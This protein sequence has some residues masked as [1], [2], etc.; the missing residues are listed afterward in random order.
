MRTKTILYTT[1]GT[2]TLTGL[3]ATTLIVLTPQPLTQTKQTPPEPQYLTTTAQGTTQQPLTQRDTYTINDP[4]K[5]TLYDAAECGPTPE[6]ELWWTIG[7]IHCQLLDDG[8]TVKIIPGNPLDLT[9]Y[10]GT[11]IQKQMAYAFEY[12]N[13]SGPN[14]GEFK[15]LDNV[16]CANFTSQTLLARGWQMDNQWFNNGGNDVSYDWIYATGLREYTLTKPGVTELNDTQRNQVK[17]GDLAQFDWE[18]TGTT[19]RDH[20]AVVS[21]IETLPDGSIKIYVIEHTDPYN[22]RD[23]DQMINQTHPGATV[24]YISIPENM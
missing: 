9:K 22:Y 11:N 4:Q 14:T 13:T 16:D 8:T 10:T 6:G 1:I 19:D 15:Y 24:Y 2:L 17:I 12:W 18:S 3:I 23:V 20:T 5:D 21:K 7:D